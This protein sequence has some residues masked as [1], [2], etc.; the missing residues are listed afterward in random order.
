MDSELKI[1]VKLNKRFKKI[2]INYID[3][4][5]KIATKIWGDEIYVYES[6]KVIYLNTNNET[7]GYMTISHGCQ[8][9]SLIDMKMIIKAASDIMATGVILIHNHP[10]G[11]VKPSK[12][13]KMLMMKIKR[14]LEDFN[15]RFVDSMIVSKTN[16][17]SF[18]QNNLLT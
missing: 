8:T 16:F 15:L 10:S 11:N 13:D 17:Y 3:D 12:Q 4:I 6:I 2:K 9:K 18:K 1:T 14:Y 5:F 7:I